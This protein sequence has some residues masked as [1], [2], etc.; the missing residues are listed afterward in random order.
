MLY[1]FDKC[2]QHPEEFEVRFLLT[3]FGLS[4]PVGDDEKGVTK[5]GFGT[6]GYRAPEVFGGNFVK[7]TDM[8]SFG[9]VMFDVASMG[10]QRAFK[11]DYEIRRYKDDYPRFP[12]PVPT[13]TCNPVPLLTENQPSCPT[14]C[15]TD[16]LSKS[17][18]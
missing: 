16:K 7:R 9:C 11:E 14:S 13:A 8:F 17:C 4:R 18:E 6:G 10:I 2:P 12:L 15:P 5:D 1:T 3:D